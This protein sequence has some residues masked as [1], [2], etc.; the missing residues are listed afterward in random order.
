MVAT[1]AEY[2]K[3]IRKL[4][5]D[6]LG[7]TREDIDGETSTNF[8]TVTA[9]NS[10]VDSDRLPGLTEVKELVKAADRNLDKA[11]IMLLWGSAGRIG[12]VLV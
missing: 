9:D 12:E 8:F 1:K 7:D 4:Y 5:K 6:Y 11:L 2:R 3:S 10:K